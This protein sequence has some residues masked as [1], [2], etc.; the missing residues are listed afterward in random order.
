MVRG[1]AAPLTRLGFRRDIRLFLAALVGYFVIVIIALVLQLQSSFLQLE[2]MHAEF[3]NATAD[4]ASDWLRQNNGGGAGDLGASLA[5]LRGRYG[6]SGISLRRPNGTLIS[7]GFTSFPSSMAIPRRTSFGTVTFTFDESSIQSQKK[8]VLWIAAICLSAT[9]AGFTLLLLYLPRI[10]RPIEE[11]L[12]YARQVGERESGVDEERFL[13]DT[14]RK[15]IEKLKEQENE[16]QRLHD[17]QKTRA[18][19]LERITATLTRSLTS[20]FIALNADAAIVDMNSAARE[21]LGIEGKAAGST[22]REIIGAGPFL[23]ALDSAVRNR[24]SLTRHEID[25]TTRNGKMVIGLTTVPLIDEFDEFLGMIALFTDLTP[26]R[27]LERQLFEMR[28]LAD[29]GEMSAGIAHEFRNSLSTILGYVRLAGRSE[30]PRDAAERLSK[31]ESE[32]GQLST[33]VE[34]LLAFARPITLEPQRIDLGDLVREIAERLVTS[35]TIGLRL[36]TAAAPV[37]ADRPLLAR[38]IENVIRNAIDAVNAKGGGTIT[39][40]VA[41]DPP[42]VTV[43]DTGIGLSPA[44]ASRLFLPFQSDK[45]SGFGLG[46]SLTRKIVVLHRGEIHLTGAPG[47]GATVTIELPSPAKPAAEERKQPQS[48]Y[49][50]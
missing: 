37:D 50:S 33:A 5:Y 1:A 26:I 42:R 27:T 49:I 12:D 44:D 48:S 45:P 25:H 43:A 18:D 8:G 7:S 24:V 11:M 13:I 46:L 9:L 47:E 10:S 14:F 31:A 17:A 35:E 29:L 32:A 40:D 28:T 6:I 19:D 34:R 16:L 39:I 22:L 2:Q 23:D 3:R 20:G 41:A 15:S 36:T 21:I 4:Y 38:A 30:L